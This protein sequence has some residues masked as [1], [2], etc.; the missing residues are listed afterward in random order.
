MVKIIDKVNKIIII[1][2]YSIIRLKVFILLIK[3]KRRPY[4]LKNNI[5]IIITLL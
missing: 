2:I 5:K 1:I 3:R 4:R